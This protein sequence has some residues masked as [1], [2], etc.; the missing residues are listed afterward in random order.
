MGTLVDITRVSSLPLSLSGVDERVLELDGGAEIFF[1][2]LF[3]ATPTA[4]GGSQPRD[5]IGATAASLHHSHS[6]TGSELRLQPPPQLRATPD[7]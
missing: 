6:N 7:P 3:R 5:L 4:H 1:F 2:L